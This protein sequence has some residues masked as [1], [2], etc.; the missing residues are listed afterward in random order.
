MSEPAAGQESAR[1]PG[2]LGLAA[3][4]VVSFTLRSLLTSIDIPY[5]RWLDEPDAALAA[6]GL[7][8]PLDFAFIACWVGTSSALTSHL[9]RALGERNEPRLRQL[10]R[11]TTGLLLLLMLGFF[12]LA[13]LAWWL[14]PHLGQLEPPV[15]R[16]F[17]IYAPIV[18]AGNALFGLWSVLP[19]SLVKAHHDTRTTMISGLASGFLNLGL[20]TLFVPVLGLGLAGL[21][22]ATTLARLGGLAYA[23]WAVRGLE[24]RRREAWAREPE[25]L[26]SALLP[27]PTRALLVLAV[28]SALT[29][30][31]VASESLIVNGALAW[32]PEATSSIAAYALYQRASVLL[33]M[34]I[35]A[36]SVA[37][38]PWVARRIGEGRAAEVGPALRR[39]HAAAYAYVLLLATPLCLL[40]GQALARA[41]GR[42][43]AT[44]ALAG[45]AIRWGAPLALCAVIPFLLAR[46]T[47]E[48]L[49]RGWP[50][51]L[52]ALLRYLALAF[53]LALGG[54]A[55]ARALG[56]EPF[57]G[58][59]GGL[60]GGSAL[61][62][63]VSAVWLRQ[64]LRRLPSGP[65][66]SA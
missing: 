54:A 27:A 51:L 50:G 43:A 21:A 2:L 61:T 16:A 60:I 28:P 1:E 62:S 24:R 30:V 13:G 18:L 49:Q 44:E 15:V 17:R 11:V 46:P 45:A 38:L 22:L 14:A 6:M 10:L 5:T 32:L 63:L 12:L 47:F 39:A 34:P 41:L 29:W 3:P 48:A 53:P 26:T 56:Q 64:A 23:S 35:V 20:N 58:L 65:P 4:L 36:L 31:L 66:L 9:S 55:L 40:G 7:F 8:F 59:V 33:S 19:D 52:L 57:L 42:A 37:V 25:R